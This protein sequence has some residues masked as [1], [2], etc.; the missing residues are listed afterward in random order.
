MSRFVI[1]IRTF[2]LHL[3]SACGR[4]RI[5]EARQLYGGG[6]SR[7]TTSV[8]AARK[9]PVMYGDRGPSMI[10]VTGA[11]AASAAA[12]TPSSPASVAPFPLVDPSNQRRLLPYQP[13]QTGSIA[14]YRLIGILFV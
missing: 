12:T 3:W 2:S 4:G 14:F 11:A 1:T 7:D 10:D 13:G 6:R 9:L 8:T 5:Q